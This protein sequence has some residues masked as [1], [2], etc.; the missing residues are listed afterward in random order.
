MLKKRLWICAL[1]TLSLALSPLHAQESTAPSQPE[2]KPVLTPDSKPDLK[3][4]TEAEALE[5]IKAASEAS[6]RAAVEKAVPLAVQ[7]TAAEYEGKIA[8]MKHDETTRLVVACLIG[9]VLGA[10]AGDQVATHWH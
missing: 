2:S 1:L 8:G 7:A 10:V 9:F 5:A 4:Y 3:L 6:A